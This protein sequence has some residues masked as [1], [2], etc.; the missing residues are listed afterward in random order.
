[1]KQRR[2]VAA[3]RSFVAKLTSASFHGP[4]EVAALV[5]LNNSEPHQ[6]NGAVPGFAVLSNLAK[7]AN[8]DRTTSSCDAIQKLNWRSKRELLA[9][10]SASGTG[11]IDAVVMASELIVL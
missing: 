6:G 4:A 5:Q 9:S 10:W 8:N 7:S 11:L 2:L 1:M 3:K